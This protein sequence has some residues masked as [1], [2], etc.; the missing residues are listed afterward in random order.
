MAVSFYRRYVKLLAMDMASLFPATSMVAP[1]KVML[2]GEMVLA[3]SMVL[4]R[5]RVPHPTCS[6]RM[7]DL[8]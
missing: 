7:S 8:V 1:A 4:V 6:L 3:F 5:I 2:T